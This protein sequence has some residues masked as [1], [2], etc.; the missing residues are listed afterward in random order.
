MSDRNESLRNQLC[1]S[2]RS[3]VHAC[4]K[5]RAL[6]RDSLS[7]RGVKGSHCVLVGEIMSETKKGE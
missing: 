3:A 1:F 6:K 4:D 2:L 7:S 5:E